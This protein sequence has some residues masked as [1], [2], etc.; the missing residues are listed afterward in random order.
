M[1]SVNSNLNKYT[2]IVEGWACRDCGADNNP[3]SKVCEICGASR[4]EIGTTLSVGGRRG[5]S[6]KGRGKSRKGRGKSRKGRDRKS[7]RRRQ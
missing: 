7:S 4:S 3:D 6:R 2:G 5:K 1:S